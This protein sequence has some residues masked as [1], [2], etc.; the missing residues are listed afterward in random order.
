MVDQTGRSLDPGTQDEASDEQRL[1]TRYIE[2]I[3][4]LYKSRD[5]QDILS[6]EQDKE[7][8]QGIQ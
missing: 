7:A 1:D 2:E 8:G 3:E 5:R 6:D 4:A